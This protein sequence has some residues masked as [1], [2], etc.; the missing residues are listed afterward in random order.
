MKT[1]VVFVVRTKDGGPAPKEMSWVN[2]CHFTS[3]DRA[4][5]AIDSRRS[6]SEEERQRCEDLVV[7]RGELQLQEL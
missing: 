2:S 1:E 3:F 5:A 7:F 6:I 4:Q